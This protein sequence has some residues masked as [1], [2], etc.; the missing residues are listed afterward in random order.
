MIRDG[1]WVLLGKCLPVL[2]LGRV[3]SLEESG[4]CARVKK[5][6]PNLAVR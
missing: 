5:L 3:V 1:V 2:L 6:E 4:M